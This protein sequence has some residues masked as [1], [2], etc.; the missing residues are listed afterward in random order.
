MPNLPKIVQSVLKKSQAFIDS[1]TRDEIAIQ[2]DLRI[3]EKII[4]Q[5]FQYFNELD[6]TD[7]QRFLLRVYHF[8]KGKKFHYIGLEPAIEIPILISAAAVQITFG[9]RKYRM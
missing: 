8:K 7:K 1:F 4:S 9:L 3:Y 5:Y 2:A 6:I